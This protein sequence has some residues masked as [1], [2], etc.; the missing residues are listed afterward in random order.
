[1]KSKDIASRFDSLVRMLD[2]EGFEHTLI[3][4]LSGGMKKR[5]NLLVSLIHN[6]PLLILDEPTVGLD[7]ILRDNLWKYIREINRSG[8]TIL[9]TSH[10]L[11]EIEENCNRI[12]IM[13]YGRIVAIAS[14]SQFKDKY[15]ED[16][17]FKDIFEHMVK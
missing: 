16:V 3:E 8:T 12:G 6:P 5:A 4:H 14:P 2:L 13:D 11:D 9:V 17:L 15:G 10:L 7:S 1:M